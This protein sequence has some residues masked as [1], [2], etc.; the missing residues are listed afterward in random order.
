[1]KTLTEVLKI[2]RNWDLL[3]LIR[4]SNIKVY[5]TLDIGTASFN[6]YIDSF[7]DTCVN[8]V[9]FDYGQVNLLII[10]MNTD[11]YNFGRR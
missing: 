1:M 5:D 3:I 7:A 4:S 6:N 9:M 10:S 8:Y 11:I 2:H